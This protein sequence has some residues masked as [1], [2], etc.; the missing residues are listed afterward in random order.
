MRFADMID[1]GAT[2]VFATSFG[3]M[4]GLEKSSKEYPEVAFMHCSGYKMTENM[5]NYFGRMYQAR[6]LS[7]IVAGLKLK[8]ITL[9][10][11]VHTKFLK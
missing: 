3:H 11:L 4:D 6:Y 10:M 9:V 7:G 2:V 5:G 8:Q 1:Q